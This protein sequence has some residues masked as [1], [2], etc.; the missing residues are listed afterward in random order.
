MSAVHVTV[1]DEASADAPAVVLVHGTMTWGTACFEAQRPLARHYRLL[2]VDRRGFGESPDIDQIRPI[3]TTAT[4]RWTLLTS[5]SCSGTE[6][7]WWDTATEVSWPC[8]PQGSARR[9]SARS[10]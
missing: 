3:S 2:A 9:P 5:S 7:I 8:L 10:R 6:P 1:W 4:T